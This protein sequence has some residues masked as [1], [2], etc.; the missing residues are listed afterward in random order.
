ME[1]KTSPIFF[2][3]IPS[4]RDDNDINAEPLLDDI[5]S[6]PSSVDWRR[7]LQPVRNQ[8]VHGTSIAHVGA[9]MIEWKIRKK[10][11]KL[12][13]MSAQYIFNKR[14]DKTNNF[15]YGREM[16][17]I[18]RDEGCCSEKIVPT[19]MVESP[20]EIQ[21]FKADANK[22]GKFAKVYTVEGLKK[23][24]TINGPCLVCFPV[25]NF[26]KKMWKQ[27]QGEDRLGGH[28]MAIVGYD[29]KGFILR[30][31]WGECWENKG[32]SYYP[33]SDW[34]CHEEIWTVIDDKNVV[35][36]KSAPTRIL[37]KAN[38]IVF[39]RMIVNEEDELYENFKE[40][41]I[42]GK[43]DMNQNKKKKKETKSK[44]PEL[45]PEPEPEAEAE[46]EEE[47]EPEEEEE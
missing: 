28:A 35:E 32:Y 36:W 37:N 13:K 16:M 17:Q 31:S 38:S 29:K 27:H 5:K 33:Y 46:P 22:I 1:T 47:P 18:L 19:G 6:V 44:T 30:N 4:P 10:E 8:S 39:R 40:H 9:C 25:F 23:T 20:D 45:K 2:N 7:Y 42:S 26:T 41:N 15:I 34:G 3:V 14:K 21:E 12:V 11:K 43:N 24:L